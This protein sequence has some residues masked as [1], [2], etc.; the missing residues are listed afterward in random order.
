[1]C[2]VPFQRGRIVCSHTCLVSYLIVDKWL[3][4]VGESHTLVHRCNVVGPHVLASVNAEA[5]TQEEAA[6]MCMHESHPVA[7]LL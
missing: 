7:Q 3:T 5:Y 4:A 1:M 6:C 2:L